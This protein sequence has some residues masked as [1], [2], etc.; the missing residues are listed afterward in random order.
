MWLCGRCRCISRRPCLTL[1]ALSSQVC[2]GVTGCD[3]GGV[4]KVWSH[5]I[6]RRPGPIPA[7]PKI[8]NPPDGYFPLHAEADE[9]NPEKAALLQAAARGPNS[10]WT[11]GVDRPLRSKHCQVG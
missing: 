2:G 7:R 9:S 4:N 11:C 6:S 5:C 1:D 8:C 3:L 10:C